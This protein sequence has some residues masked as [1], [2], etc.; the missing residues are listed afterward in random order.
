MAEEHPLMLEAVV[1]RAQAPDPHWRA[2]AARSARTCDALRSY[3]VDPTI[4]DRDEQLG[5]GMGG[6]KERNL[7]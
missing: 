7:I 5:A 4:H 1:A 2:G 6:G 3:L